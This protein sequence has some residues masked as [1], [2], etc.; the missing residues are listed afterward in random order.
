MKGRMAEHILID[1]VLPNVYGCEVQYKAPNDQHPFDFMFHVGNMFFAGECKATSML[2]NFPAYAI[3]KRQHDKYMN[4]HPF[5]P[6]MFVMFFVDP[7]AG[8]IYAGS[9]GGMLRGCK[10]MVTD[11]GHMV[12]YQVAD[13][14]RLDY[15][16]PTYDCEALL[17]YDKALKEYGYS[18]DKSPAH[19]GV[20]DKD[21]G[22]M[23]FV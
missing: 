11:R 12:M 4:I 2:E 23:V 1:R 7:H 18:K 16:I 3:S 17:A 22:F 6:D 14:Y 13:M 5:S 19:R 10:N 15:D 8:S 9:L 21:L 20:I